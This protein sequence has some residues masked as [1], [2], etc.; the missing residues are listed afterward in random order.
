[1][2]TKHDNYEEMI[3]NSWETNAN[4]QLGIGGLW[5]RLRDM[6]ADMK[7]WSFETFGSVRAELKSLRGKLEEAK[8][9]SLVSGASQ[10]V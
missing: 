7:K 2:W 9:Q 6:S 8:A 1:M 4:S 10:E 5:Q 3:A